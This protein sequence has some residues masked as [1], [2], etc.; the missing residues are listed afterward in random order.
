MLVQVEV[1]A[2]GTVACLAEDDEFVEEKDVSERALV[3]VRHD[4]L[5]LAHQ[6]TLLVQV[7]LRAT[8]ITAAHPARAGSPA[9]QHTLLVQVHLRAT[10]I[11]PAHPARVGSPARHTNQTLVRR[12]AYLRSS[13]SSSS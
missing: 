2:A 7:H 13:S 9:Q 10:P 5:A 6:H 12:F 3:S 4:E 1:V 11:T 8:P